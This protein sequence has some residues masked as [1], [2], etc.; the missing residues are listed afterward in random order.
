MTIL[1]I[2]LLCYLFLCLVIFIF[3]DKVIFIARKFNENSPSMSAHKHEEITIE[4]N[5][6]RLHGWL[7]NPGN[8]KLI[9]YYG[10]SAE[11]V[12]GRI[13]ELALISN[14]TSLVLNYRGYGIS[15]GSPTEKGLLDDA[16]KV[17]DKVTAQLNIPPEKV[18]LL[19]WSLGT[20]VAVHVACQRNVSKVI[21]T[22]PFDNHINVIKK[23]LP[24]FPFKLLI[25]HPFDSV[26]I[27][28]KIK[29]PTMIFIA[30]NDKVIS[31]NSSMN[32]ANHIT[33]PLNIITIKDAGHNDIHSFE[34][35]VTEINDFINKDLS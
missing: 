24:I 28:D 7:L 4:V 2:I 3:Q 29:A 12:S 22:T 21:L 32:L 5:K 17:F 14:Y 34:R 25:R 11:E 16:V 27:A 15:E 31:L 26:S 6:I 1:L 20:S 35:Y 13:G 19:G 10:G 33:A 9:I 30:E 18:I 23:Y 8:D